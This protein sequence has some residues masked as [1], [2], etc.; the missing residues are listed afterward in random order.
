MRD[1]ENGRVLV[2]HAAAGRRRAALHRPPRP[3]LLDLRARARRDRVGAPAV[4]AARRAREDLPSSTLRNTSARARRLSVTLYVE[5][6]LGETPVAHA[7]ARRHQPRAGDR[8]GA[9]HQR[10][11]RAVRRSRG[12][13]RSARRIRRGRAHGAAGADDHRRSHRVHRPERHAAVARPRCGRRRAVR[14]RRAG[15]RSLRRRAAR[16]RRWNRARSGR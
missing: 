5:W 13:P 7:P 6:V 2:G 11:P 9:R 15:A 4:R 12:V 16:R 3:G 14:P 8:R 1:E 10:L